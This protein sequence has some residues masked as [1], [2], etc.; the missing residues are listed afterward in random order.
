VTGPESERHASRRLADAIR[1]GIESGAYPPG[2]RLPSYRQLR[3]EHG[4]A[5]NTSSAAIRLLAADGLVEIRPA[6]GAWVRG[7]GPRRPALRSE[8]AEVQDLLRRSRQNLTAAE[9]A[10]ASLLSRLPPDEHGG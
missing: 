7:D 10:L 5:L 8:L 9:Q 3:D 2:S 6:R 1:A 4:V